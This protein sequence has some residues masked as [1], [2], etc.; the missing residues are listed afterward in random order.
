MQLSN[1]FFFWDKKKKEI[2]N[3]L[4]AHMSIIYDSYYT[5]CTKWFQLCFAI[6]KRYEG[7]HLRNSKVIPKRLSPFEA[8]WLSL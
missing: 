4:H 5:S 2:D 7:T 6:G 3:K 1:F 8:E